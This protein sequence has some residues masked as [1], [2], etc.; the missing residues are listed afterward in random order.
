MGCWPKSQFA[1]WKKT[2]ETAKVG[3]DEETRKQKRTHKEKEAGRISVLGMQEWEHV[4]SLSFSWDTTTMRIF[5]RGVSNQFLYSFLPACNHVRI[6]LFPKSPTRRHK[7]AY[8]S[9]DF[10]ISWISFATNFT[11]N[12][13]ACET[14][15]LHTF[16]NAQCILGLTCISCGS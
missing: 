14:S 10:L 2:G 12:S 4:S 1:D 16:I 3:K 5:L 11:K 7:P 9:K 13:L 8:L 6:W 15:V